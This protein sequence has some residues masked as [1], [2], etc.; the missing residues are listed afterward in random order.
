VIEERKSVRKKL[1]IHCHLRYG[2]FI[3]GQ[4]NRDD[5]RMFVAMTST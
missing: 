5:D 1:T 2:Y 3:N 4:P